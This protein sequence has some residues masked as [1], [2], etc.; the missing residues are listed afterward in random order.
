MLTL[1]PLLCVVVTE[2]NLPALNLMAPLNEIKENVEEAIL[3]LLAKY[4]H[5]MEPLTTQ[6]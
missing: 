5:S 1:Q 6:S 4:C 3:G 2:S